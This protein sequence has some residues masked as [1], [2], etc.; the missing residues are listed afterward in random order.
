MTYM[1]GIRSIESR[2][3]SGVALATEFQLLNAR[4][5][6]KGDYLEHGEEQIWRLFA[7]WQ[8]TKWTGMVKYPDSFNIQDRYNDVVM[9]KTV[10]DAKPTNPVLIKQAEKL[11]LMSIIDDDRKLD[12]LLEDFDEAD[13]KVVDQQEVVA[14]ET[15]KSEEHPSLANKTPAER[16]AHLQTMLMEGY[17]ND[18]IIA[19]HPEITQQDIIDAGAAAAASN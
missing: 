5:S 14:P 17:S 15:P 9:Y 8:G 13:S 3:L 18:E 19:L 4:L 7:L 11:M 16:L 2:R 12:D 1:G 6:E 10:L